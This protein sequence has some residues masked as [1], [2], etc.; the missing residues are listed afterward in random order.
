MPLSLLGER[1][2][3]DGAFISRRGPGEG[4]PARP[5]IVNNS[6]KQHA[7]P[8]STLFPMIL[9]KSGGQLAEVA[10]FQRGFLET[11]EIVTNYFAY[12]LDSRGSGRYM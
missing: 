3:R 10:C 7:S 11:S 6:V 8:T 5:L 9:A 1:V 2:A 12:H 4:V